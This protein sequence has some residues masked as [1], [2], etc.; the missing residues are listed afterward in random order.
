[1]SEQSSSPAEQRA[2]AV[3]KLK[4]A[5]SLPRM[6]NGRRPPLHA[7]GVSEGDQSKLE[8]DDHDTS[9]GE[10]SSK[11]DVEDGGT[12]DEAV[13]APPAES[14]T[15]AD[16]AKDTGTESEKTK[17]SETEKEKEK[18]GSVKKRGRSRSRSR[19]RSRGSK[20]FKDS[21]RPS[22]SSGPDEHA[23]PIPMYSPLP[24]SMS[25][26]MSSPYPMLAPS[27][28]YY[29][30]PSPL[31]FYPPTNPPTPNPLPSFETLIMR[32][33]LMR[34]N[35]AA[36]RMTALQKLTG[37]RETPETNTFSRGSP[38]PDPSLAA[39][40][41][42]SRTVAGGERLELRSKMLKQLGKRVNAA[43]ISEDQ[44]SGGEDVVL[45]S[46]VIEEASKPPSRRNSTKRRSTPASNHTV[47]VDDREPPV[48]APSTPAISLNTFPPLPP[49]P[50]DSF[51][52]VP[53]R[54]TSR[55]SST[56]ERERDSALAKLEG[57]ESFEFDAHLRRSPGITLTR[58]VFVEEEEEPDDDDVP[59]TQLYRSNLPQAPRTPSRDI[60]I[61]FSSNSSSI[62]TSTSVPIYLHEEGQTSPYKE[63]AFPVTIS[64]FG[65][66][67]R[68]KPPRDDEDEEEEENE[69]V[70]YQ[71]DMG[72]RKA[73]LERTERDVEWNVV[74][75]ARNSLRIIK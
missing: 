66:P 41:S 22:D 60:R 25:S 32:T 53:P 49:P 63:D 52:P 50:P 2:N 8:G 4:R 42:R 6:K 39:K 17:E 11:P 34:S 28:G 44:I 72:P 59:L 27:L 58:G 16:Q 75:G 35:S 62:S 23:P 54:P 67:I 31:Q 1:M 68:E 26:P 13:S 61:P 33:N 18:L 64:P 20:D 14:Q 7:E 15:E 51:L 10:K 9:G 29:P 45:T 48:T 71:E 3:A 73:W 40:L 36:A 56:G 43:D 21:L 19:S 38:S 37:G 5:A 24:S 46:Q 30:S 70:V 57:E 12:V 47:V 55:A 74:P 65:T 69:R